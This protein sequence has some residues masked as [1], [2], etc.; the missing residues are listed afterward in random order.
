MADAPTLFDPSGLDDNFSVR[1]GNVISARDLA[2]AAR[3]L[4]A[5]P[6]LAPIVA[7][8]ITEFTGPD[9][10]AHRLINHNKLLTRYAGAIGMKTG[11][12]KKSGHGLIAA[13]TRNG[14]TEIVV[15][16]NAVDTY[17][18]A[19]QLLD[20]AFALPVPPNADR[21]P[22]IRP[23]LHIAAAPLEL[24]ATPAAD[25]PI[26][27]PADVT[28]STTE[29]ASA[30]GLPIVVRAVLWVFAALF[31]A[32]CVLRARVAIRRQRRRHKRAHARVHRHVHR[33]RDPQLTPHYRPED[34]LAERFH[35]AG[36][37]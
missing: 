7:R 13:A 37:R 9:G 20:A 33:R 17:G 2:I 21:L 16:L 28:A 14:R 26:D 31:A 11:Y 6:R 34:E 24:T 27:D 12:T 4:L 30:G 23:A 3:A 32:W 5:D 1:G 18:W 8:P 35:T 10:L 22:A 19:A 29:K 15:V 25:T 36:R